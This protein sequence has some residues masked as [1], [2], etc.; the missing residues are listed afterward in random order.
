MV[1]EYWM[2]KNSLFS[3]SLFVATDSISN[4]LGDAVLLFPVIPPLLS[5]ILCVPTRVNAV[6]RA[7]TLCYHLDR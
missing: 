5:L 6:T 7:M 2:G 3:L 1:N 4:F